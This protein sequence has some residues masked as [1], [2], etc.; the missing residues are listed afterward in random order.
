MSRTIG[1]IFSETGY[2]FMMDGSAMAWAFLGY[3]VLLVFAWVQAWLICS[4]LISGLIN[5]FKASD[6]F[7]LRF[8]GASTNI[9]N[10]KKK[11]IGSIQIVLAVCMAL[12]FVFGMPDGAIILLSGLAAIGTIP[13]LI[14]AERFIIGNEGSS[15]YFTGLMRGITVS[16]AVVTASFSVYEQKDG[17]AFSLDQLLKAQEYRTAEIAWQIQSDKSSPKEGDMAPDFELIDIN[18]MPRRLSD[19]LGEKPVFL[20]FGA[21]SCPPFSQGTLG[22]NELQEKYGDQ[23]E[24]VGVYVNE[25]H[26]TDGWWLAASKIQQYFF[27]RS[28][29]R[30]AIDIVQPTTQEQRN[31]FAKRAHENLLNEDIPLLVDSINNKVSNMYTGQPTRIYILDKDGRVIYNQGIGPYSFSPPHAE[32]VIQQ[33]LATLQEGF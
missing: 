2:P 19:Y 10:D 11:L 14:Y 9:V 17:L 32:P 30:A 23:M 25:P 12:P 7:L 31:L 21:N 24:F 15:R 26:P 1:E 27:Q 8:L 28:G 18:G 16:L 5:R 29:S 22:I 4:V 20:F 33:H 6:L 3:S 13:C